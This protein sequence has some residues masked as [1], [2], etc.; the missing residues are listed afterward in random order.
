[1]EPLYKEAMGEVAHFVGAQ[2]DNIVIII[3]MMMIMVILMI[4]WI[5]VKITMRLLTLLAHLS[6]L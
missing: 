6:I 4:M 2:P 1:M 3:I 5:T